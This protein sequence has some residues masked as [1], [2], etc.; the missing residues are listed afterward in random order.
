MITRDTFIKL[1]TQLQTLEDPAPLQLLQ[2]AIENLW[3]AQHAKREGWSVSAITAHLVQADRHW[4][5]L[6]AYF[7]KNQSTREALLDV[8]EV[9]L[10]ASQGK[11]GSN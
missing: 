7:A 1:R 11:A 8:L 4:R 5:N 2:A 9:S 3:L 6:D 10:Q